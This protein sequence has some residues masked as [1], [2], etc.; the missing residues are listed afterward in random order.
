MDKEKSRA[1]T[2]SREEFHA[3]WQSQFD[4][5]DADRDGV[6]KPEELLPVGLFGCF[7][8][9]QDGQVVPAE[10]RKMYDWHFNRHDKNRDGLVLKGE[11]LN[12]S[13]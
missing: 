7:D 4:R 12:G 11:M 8:A 10:Y 9:N 13:K 6:L 1:R 5:Q 2:V 3:Y